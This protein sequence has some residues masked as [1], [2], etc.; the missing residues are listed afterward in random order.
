[1]QATLQKSS[2]TDSGRSY[3]Q[4]WTLNQN[5]SVFIE[6]R[7]QYTSEISPFVN[8]EDLRLTKM[9]MDLTQTALMD[10]WDNETDNYWNS[11]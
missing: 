2:Y 6:N 4:L 11:L 3:L 8:L 5:L 1:M 7:F 9:A 10:V